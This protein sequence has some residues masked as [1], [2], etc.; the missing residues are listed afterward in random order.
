[1]NSSSDLISTILEEPE[2]ISVKITHEKFR[3]TMSDFFFSFKNTEK[4]K[5]QSE[6]KNPL[7]IFLK[8]RYLGTSKEFFEI[9]WKGL[10]SE[11][12]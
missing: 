7:K 5:S 4:Y 10:R 12:L 8:K 2:I 6:E 9:A 11:V 1:M 3:I